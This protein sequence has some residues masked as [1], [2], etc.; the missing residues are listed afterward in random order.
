MIGVGRV[1]SEIEPL[2]ARHNLNFSNEV[3]A[4]KQPRSVRRTLKFLI[5]VNV[6][7]EIEIDVARHIHHHL[8]D[9]H[10]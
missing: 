2:R 4:H 1:S 9:E 3:V 8:A 10:G 5:Y 6:F 7:D